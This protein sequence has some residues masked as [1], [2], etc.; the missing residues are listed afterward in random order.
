MAHFAG[1][2]VITALCGLAVVRIPFLTVMGLAG[3]SAVLIA[4]AVST[5]LLPAMMGF[6]GEWL[7]PK[8]GSRAARRE[9]ATQQPDH[10]GRRPFGERWG[11]AAVRR[12]MPTLLAVLLGLL[13]VAVRARDL[14]PAL[15]DN[16]SAAVDGTRRKAYDVVSEK[17]GPSFNGPLLI[18]ADTSHTDDPGRVQPLSPRS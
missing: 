3:A 8:P 7:R 18:L 14:Q 1:L 17:F 9:R 5:T 11:R 16:G 13:A 4:V 10:G 2:T 6:A 15:P 12:P